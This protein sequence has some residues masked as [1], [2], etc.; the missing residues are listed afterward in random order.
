MIL[1]DYFGTS[2]IGNRI[3]DHLQHHHS[4]HWQNKIPTLTTEEIQ[5]LR[6]NINYVNDHIVNND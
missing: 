1:K 4:V 5:L 2:A 6:E 3:L